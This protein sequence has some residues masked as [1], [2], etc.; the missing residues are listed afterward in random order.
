MLSLIQED[1]PL[2]HPSHPHIAFISKTCAHKKAQHALAT[3][4]HTHWASLSSTHQHSLL[5]TCQHHP[6][7]SLKPSKLL[8]LSSCCSFN[9]QFQAASHLTPPTNTQRSSCP[10]PHLNH[11]VNQ[12]GPPAE[13][14]ATSRPPRIDNALRWRQLICRPLRGYPGA[15]KQC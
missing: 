10:R 7:A 13:G 2:G 9:P 3:V 14:T 4:S 15:G 5:A 1:S 12:I 11:V 8:A 6:C